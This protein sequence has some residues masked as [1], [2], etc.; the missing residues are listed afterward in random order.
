MNRRIKIAGIVLFLTGIMTL[1]YTQLISQNNTSFRQPDK[2]SSQTSSD[3]QSVVA[4]YDLP[5]QL[6]SERISYQY[7]IYYGFNEEIEDTI[8]GYLCKWDNSFLDSNKNV[9]NQ[10]IDNHILSLNHKSKQALYYNADILGQQSFISNPMMTIADM[11]MENYEFNEHE[12]FLNNTICIVKTYK[13]L[14]D[15]LL[16]KELEVWQNKETGTVEKMKIIIDLEEI[17][18]KPITVR[19]EMKDIKIGEEVID[20]RKNSYIDASIAGQIKLSDKFKAYQ[21]QIL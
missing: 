4:K 14:S 16:V 17:Y 3:T 7:T 21:L 13:L 2:E 20:F 12:G 15:N 18:N 9:L 10:R 8:N 5:I 1:V 11:K 6:Q 19:I